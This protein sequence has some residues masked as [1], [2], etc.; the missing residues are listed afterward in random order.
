MAFGA[1]LGRRLIGEVFGSG[2]RTKMGQT[3]AQE[4]VVGAASAGLGVASTVARGAVDAL[5]NLPVT[6]MGVL[7]GSGMRMGESVNQGIHTLMKYSKE[8]QESGGIFGGIREA[9]AQR[10]AEAA[11]AASAISGGT[12]A[13]ASTVARVGRTGRQALLTTLEGTGVGAVVAVPSFGVLGVTGRDKT[14]RERARD[15]YGEGGTGGGYVQYP[16]T[17]SLPPDI[18]AD[19]DLAL[20]LHEVYG[21]GRKRGS[22]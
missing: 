19:G 21:T 11:D 12:V 6:R 8:A 15:V 14:M 9:R 5:T 18:N 10:A 22:R 2:A 7:R 3:L 13:Q 20:A 1:I 4:V 16:G 17:A